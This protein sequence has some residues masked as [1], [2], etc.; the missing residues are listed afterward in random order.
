MKLDLSPAEIAARK[1][2]GIA[3]TEPLTADEIKAREAERSSLLA[4]LGAASVADDAPQAIPGRPPVDKLTA[5]SNIEAD[6]LRAQED[7]KRAQAEKLIAP[8][9]EAGRSAMTRMGQMKAKH[10]ERVA[11][12]ANLNVR[13]ILKRVPPQIVPG[14]DYTP[15]HVDI[16]RYVALARDLLESFER[17]KPVDFTDALQEVESLAH[18]KP[19]T[20]EF[21]NAV[22]NHLPWHLKRLV[23][24]VD[25]TAQKLASFTALGK[26]IE[27]DLKNAQLVDVPVEPVERIP[28]L[29]PDPPKRDT[30]SYVDWCPFEG[31]PAPPAGP[32]VTTVA[33]GEG[34][35]V[36]ELNPSTQPGVKVVGIA[37]GA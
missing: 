25:A 32:K 5:I 29:P 19:M 33:A 18:G 31:V 14:L 12:A 26:K 30:S 22:Q 37:G 16:T 3:L 7:E 6:A 13:A 27:A 4:T 2:A 21:I 11:E 1:R 24:S 10:Q 28:M 15:N 17:W 20:A 36:G 9:R 35:R 23:A 34:K 8:H